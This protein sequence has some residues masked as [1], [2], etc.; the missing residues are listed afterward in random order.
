MAENVSSKPFWSPDS[1]FIGFGVDG[2]PGSLKKIDTTSGVI[3]TVCTY[4]GPFRG[5]SWNRTGVI[6]FGA[7]TEGIAR[8][9]A[10]GGAST[11]LTKV[12]TSRQE[13][14][15]AG[16]AFL[17]DGRRFLYTRTSRVPDINGIYVGSIDASPDQQSVTRSI[18]AEAEPV[19][20]PS[21]SSQ[22]GWVLYLRQGALLAQPVDE[23]VRPIG[24][25]VPLAEDVG[26]TGTYGWFS[27][28]E[29]GTLA[30]RAGRAALQLTE[31]RWINRQGQ[32]L[33]QLGPRADYLEGIQLSRDGKRVMAA[34]PD[35]TAA[36][37]GMFSFQVSR[38]WAADVD[39]GVFS[40]LNPGEGTESSPAA[41]PDGRIIFSSTAGGAVG[42]LYSMPANG[43]G[44]SQPLL[45]K[46]PTI[47]HPNDVSPD[48][49][50]LIF[51]DHSVQQRQDLWILPLDAPAGKA[52]PIPFL[53]TPADETFA[54]FSPD[55][56]WI[57]YTSDE[58]GRR[59]VY[60]Q[61][62]APDRVPAAA[63]G[64]WPISTAGGNKPRWR[65]D[66]K[67]LYYLAPDGKLM[68]VPLKTGPS[69]FSPGVAVPLFDVR[70]TGF[71]PYAIAPDGRFLINVVA[72]AATTAT[73]VTVVF[74][75]QAAL[76]K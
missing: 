10:S 65:A 52:T 11:A 55:G 54:Q 75:W 42:D 73:P 46:S 28:S 35:D 45:V 32:V 62:F 50:F 20:V 70:A 37:N 1:R 64:K 43:I 23:M 24:D 39:R 66:G 9:S 72:D 17:S 13:R 36:A 26:I 8:V 59:E 67:E 16:P 4:N 5:G 49:R 25:S 6:V 76:K 2:F 29:T 58:S 21:P 12:N 60:V 27:A 53:V 71:F 15:H 41:L 38:I 74:N 40:R 47:K 30:Y 69:S 51:D 14:Q 31:L 33:G 48:G 3:Q 56:K 7:G 63:I 61:G 19:F 57:A 22:G 34:R 18:A 44:Q 68:A